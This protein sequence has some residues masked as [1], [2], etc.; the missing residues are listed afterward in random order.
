[1]SKEELINIIE[2]YAPNKLV[3]SHYHVHF[4][5]LI[6]HLKELEDSGFTVELNPEFQRGHVWT[7][8]QQITFIEDFVAGKLPEH[9]KRVLFNSIYDDE[10]TADEQVRGKMLCIDGLQRLTA[11]LDFINGKFNIYNGRV[12]YQHLLET[13]VIHRAKYLLSFDFYEIKSYKELLQLYIDLNS[14]GTV[15]SADEIERVQQ[16]SCALAET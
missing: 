1:M 4:K 9:I 16:M 11:C 13:G 3:K 2:Q 7:L 8:E 14:R 10:N 15:H 12:N 5:D 6:N